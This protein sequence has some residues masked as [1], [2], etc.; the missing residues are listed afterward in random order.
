MKVRVIDGIYKLRE[1]VI[2]P[3]N[4]KIPGKEVVVQLDVRPAVFPTTFLPDDLEALDEDAAVYLAARRL[5][6]SV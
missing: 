2:T 4:W 6:G 1:G 3:S 5:G